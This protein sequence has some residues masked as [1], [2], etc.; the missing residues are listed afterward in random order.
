M[1]FDGEG[2]LQYGS[3]IGWDPSHLNPFQ[4]RVRHWIDQALHHE[5]GPQLGLA[6]L[7]VRAQPILTAD[8]VDPLC[9]V[10]LTRL[11][12]PLRCG[13][14]LLTDRQREVADLVRIGQLNHEIA[15]TLGISVGT[16][17]VHLRTIF[18]TLG[19]R[20]RAEL[21]AHLD[22]PADAR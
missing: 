1:I 11:P 2:R 3:T 12:Y 13:R 21:G 18:R 19:V 5:P 4:A 14:H 22:A 6:D 8:E 10:Q 15:Q 16:V 9:L 7:S 17:K 20:S